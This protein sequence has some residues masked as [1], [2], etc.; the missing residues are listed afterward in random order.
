MKRTIY[1]I[2]S[3]LLCFSL[4]SGCDERYTYLSTKPTEEQIMPDITAIIGNYGN[5]DDAVNKET[6]E[7]TYSYIYCVVNGLASTDT[8]YVTPDEAYTSD[9]GTIVAVKMNGIWNLGLDADERIRVDVK[10]IEYITPVTINA[11]DI[12]IVDI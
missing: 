7:P 5:E 12:T 8:I 6:E 10:S 11:S 1:L 9:L 2:I 3:L 4:L